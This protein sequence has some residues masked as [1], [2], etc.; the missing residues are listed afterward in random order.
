[1]ETKRYLSS[2]IFEQCT[3]LIASIE[4]IILSGS[5]YSVYDDDAPHVDPSVF[6]LGIP[7]LGICYGLQVVSEWNTFSNFV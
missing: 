5:P 6:D 1:M 4:G 2:N 7:V 3:C